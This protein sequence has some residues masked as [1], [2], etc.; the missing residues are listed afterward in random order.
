MLT[1]LISVNHTGSLKF[2]RENTVD[3]PK[4]QLIVT[5]KG[6]DNIAYKIKTT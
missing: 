4:A 1:D 2:T 3:P 5:N 6:T